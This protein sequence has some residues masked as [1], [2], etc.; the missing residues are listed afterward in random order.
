ML[1][2]VWGN[3]EGNGDASND[4]PPAKKAKKKAAGKSSASSTKVV[5]W[6]CYL[7]THFVNSDTLTLME[8]AV[9]KK[10]T[11][12]KKPSPGECQHGVASMK[13]C[14]STAILDALKGDGD[15]VRAA[16]LKSSL[17]TKFSRQNASR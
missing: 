8:G 3:D 5:C 10:L 6:N 17:R 14:K 4:E 16:R 12:Y 11:A 7:V 13:S 2:A 9:L 15:I 1:P